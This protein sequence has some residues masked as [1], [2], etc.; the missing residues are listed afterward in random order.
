MVHLKDHYPKSTRR[1][2]PYSWCSYSRPD[3]GS[4]SAAGKDILS[5]IS[6]IHEVKYRIRRAEAKATSGF[7]HKAGPLNARDGE[8]PERGKTRVGKSQSTDQD[9]VLE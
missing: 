5:A 7:M 1:P 8:I 3:T 9:E 4:S 6:M 2:I